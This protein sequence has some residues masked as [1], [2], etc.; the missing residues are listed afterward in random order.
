M[1]LIGHRLLSA[2]AGTLQHEI[3]HADATPI[4]RRA[5]QRFLRRSGAQV[6]PPILTLVRGGGWHM[7][8]LYAHCMAR[9]LFSTTTC[10]SYSY[11]ISRPF[12]VVHLMTNW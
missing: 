5:N 8:L 6:D 7:S 1:Y 3:R 12:D 2:R 11:A 4:S 10:L 9:Y